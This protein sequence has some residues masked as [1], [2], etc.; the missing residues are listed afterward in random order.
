VKK[1]ISGVTFHGGNPSWKFAAN[2][3]SKQSEAFG[4]FSEFEIYN[5]RQ[6][7]YNFKLKHQK[8]INEHTRGFG[9]WIWKPQILLQQ[10]LKNPKADFYYYQDA[11]G[12][13]FFSSRSKIILEENLE[14]AREYGVFAFESKHKTINYTK[15]SLL[16]KYT[17]NKIDPYS[18][19]C[20]AGSIIVRND[21]LLDFVGW[22][23]E[24][25]S[26]YENLTDPKSTD[27]EKP[28]YVAH[29]HDQSCL[30]FILK[31]RGI[32]LSSDTSSESIDELIRNESPIW[33]VRNNSRVSIVV[34][35]KSRL[36]DRFQIR[37][38]KHFPGAFR[39]NSIAT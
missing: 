5:P 13:L 38:Y 15:A 6:L 37:A 3:L 35:K 8:F 19:Q 10:Y 34:E 7:A 33:N 16:E 32:P 1:N 39:W 2:R 11:G 30:D 14:Q 20:M 18:K 36:R 17:L 21:Y 29:R 24:M 31:L 12:E 9:L 27:N 23:S 28:E 25:M 26:D 4:L 22:W